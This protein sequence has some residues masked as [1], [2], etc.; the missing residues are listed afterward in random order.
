MITG[1]DLVESSRRSGQPIQNGIERPVHL[2]ACQM[3]TNA[4]VGAE[5]KTKM[6]SLGPEDVE[7]IRIGKD[8]LVAI[9]DTEAQ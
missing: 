1:G 9:G 4:D 8:S 5:S 3:L 6:S 7:L 2:H